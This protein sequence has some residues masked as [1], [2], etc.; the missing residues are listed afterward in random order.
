L[1]RII[2]IMMYL[3]Y[4]RPYASHKSQAKLKSKRNRDT[5]KPLSPRTGFFDE[6]AT[7]MNNNPKEGGDSGEPNTYYSTKK[8]HQTQQRMYLRH[9]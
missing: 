3:H 4:L 2:K 6:P 8:H 1:S 9:R 5:P 7:G